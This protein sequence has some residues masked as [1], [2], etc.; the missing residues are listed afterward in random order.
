MGG[1]S[2]LILFSVAPYA[3]RVLR[4]PSCTKLISCKGDTL[5]CS[6]PV[7]PKALLASR[8]TSSSARKQHGVQGPFRPGS[9]SLGRSSFT[10]PAHEVLQSHSSTKLGLGREKRGVVSCE[11]SPGTAGHDT[12][13]YTVHLG[14]GNFNSSSPPPSPAEIS[15][16]P[17]PPLASPTHQLPHDTSSASPPA[18]VEDAEGLPPFA[19]QAA[20]ADNPAASITNEASDPTLCQTSAIGSDAPAGPGGLAGSPGG[21]TL[22]E[23][24]P[25]LPL[26][27]EGGS[28]DSTGGSA[29]DSVDNVRDS[30][31]NA[32]GRDAGGDGSGV[33]YTRVTRQLARAEA[34]AA[35][36][37]NGTTAL[38]V[39]YES[40]KPE[41]ELVAMSAASAPAIDEIFLEDVR[42]GR[43]GR[44]TSWP[45][46]LSRA[47]GHLL[48]LPARAGL[49]ERVQQDA[50]AARAAVKAASDWLLRRPSSGEGSG[51]ASW[52]TDVIQLKLLEDPTAV[53]VRNLRPPPPPSYR[54]LS[55][56]QVVAA[57]IE[58]LRQLAGYARQVLDTWK[59]PLQLAYD[60]DDVAAALAPV[61]TSLLSDKSLLR[62][63]WSR[64]QINAMKG[65]GSTAARLK[66]A[67]VGLGP[68]FIKVAQS[69]SARP[70]LIGPYA[71]NIL[72]ELQD[73]LPPFPT[74][75]ALA[76]VEQELGR[77][78]EAVFSHLSPEPVA[79][80]SFG[81]VS[82]LYGE[83]DYR[84]EA[85]NAQ[86]FAVRVGVESSLVQLLDT[87]VM[88][89]DPHPG[90]FLITPSGHARHS[91]AML[92]AIAHLVNAEWALLTQDLDAMDVLK[93]ST[94]RRAITQALEQALGA[95]P[96]A[97][98][99]DGIP[100]INFG[101]VTSELWKIALRFRFKL[102][103]YYTLVLRSLASLEGIGLAVDPGFKVFAY[104]YPYVLRRLLTNNS[105]SSRAV[106]RQNLSSLAESFTSPEAA[107]LRWR[108]ATA[109]ADALPSLLMTASP[110][111]WLQIPKRP[112]MLSSRIHMLSSAYLAAPP[113]LP[114]ADSSA[115]ASS[116]SSSALVEGAP[117]DPQN[118][119]V[120]DA[121]PIR[122]DSELL[123][124]PDASSVGSAPAS[125]AGDESLPSPAAAAAAADLQGLAAEA[126]GGENGALGEDALAPAWVGPLATAGTPRA[127]LT[128][129]DDVVGGN[130]GREVESSRGGGGGGAAAELPSVREA[131]NVV[132]LL[133]LPPRGSERVRKKRL[134]FMLRALLARLR[135]GPLLSL[136]LAL[137]AV[138]VVLGAIA[139]AVGR[140]VAVFVARVAGRER[141]RATEPAPVDVERAPNAE[142][143][144]TVGFEPEPYGP[145]LGPP[146]P[147]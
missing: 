91:A 39:E 97:V 142:R 30:L 72:A 133:P 115:T 51:G 34:D 77:P 37:V 44:R 117:A 7:K 68:T 101:Q 98:V 104:A 79:A 43:A 122:G 1:S 86:E 111:A 32:G 95:G 29:G 9:G 55:P 11:A 70:D 84:Q 52:L 94:D 147:A 23:P 31:D 10:S 53:P 126:A 5:C 140:A 63:G 24:A 19:S 75:Q 12:A 130:V 33:I 58:Y 18:H 4:L 136:K 20:L 64:A 93:P 116:S 47:A 119:H 137:A 128:S 106:L 16:L 57:D 127:G 125:N 108:L 49:G 131:A 26:G 81:Q 109:L 25:S 145:P 41:V 69:L 14:S 61:G 83:L 141:G 40:R 74:E 107:S 124:Q 102:P 114:G 121:H 123:A 17:P 80:A 120:H 90:N 50:S 45:A 65:D 54:G 76:L 62:E 36:I 92:A 118:V 88:H 13:E 27:T 71:A 110:P 112:K 67:L 103:P 38:S 105:P 42:D 2:A 129:P 22:E 28:S 144:P 8:S 78:V 60:P 82:G 56:A 85:S 135:C 89:A 21:G 134:W 73:R 15:A 6:L 87:G 143:G 3:D 146:Q 99:K 100:N 48:S 66:R 132:G 96:T 113:A 46:L 139:L 59:V 35:Q 138:S